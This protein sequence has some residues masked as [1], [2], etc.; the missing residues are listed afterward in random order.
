[1][2]DAVAARAIAERAHAG[3]TDIHGVP[4]IEHVRR[5]AET[6]PA[7]C[8][9]L[10]WLHDTVEDTDVT[11]EELRAQG[12]S[13][14]LLAALALLTRPE[15]GDEPYLDYVRRVA[16]A[17]GEAGRLARQVKRADLRDNLG[18]PASPEK[19]HLRERY[20]AAVALIEDSI[21]ARGE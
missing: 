16:G 1:M 13:E 15:T 12:A 21:V 18:R 17:E 20:L 5:V 8:A 6:V 11:P 9:A 19:A 14:T 4:Y 3:V 7:D 2:I 10:A